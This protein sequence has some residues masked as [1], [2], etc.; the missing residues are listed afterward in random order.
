MD[1][2]KGIAVVPVRKQGNRLIIHVPDSLRKSGMLAYGDYVIL[3]KVRG[4]LNAET[5]K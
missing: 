5:V 2:N 4:V 3:Q 1:E